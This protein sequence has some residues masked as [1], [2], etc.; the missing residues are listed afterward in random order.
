MVAPR[1]QAEVLLA[2]GEAFIAAA[3]APRVRRRSK[4]VAAMP[5]WSKSLV[6]VMTGRSSAIK[7]MTRRR[8]RRPAI[9]SARRRIPIVAARRAVEA[10]SAPRRTPAELVVVQLA[11]FVESIRVERGRIATVARRVDVGPGLLGVGG[12]DVGL[13]QQH[14]QKIFVAHVVGNGRQV[15]DQ[16]GGAG[17]CRGRRQ[18]Q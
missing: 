7:V 12:R 3:F 2:A 13:R 10:R 17:T 11:E 5:R 6:G 18:R 4:I 15:A 8:P 1:R 9:V 14:V 16:F